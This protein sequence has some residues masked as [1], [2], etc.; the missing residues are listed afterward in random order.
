MSLFKLHID[1]EKETVAKL[2]EED[3]IVVDG[4]LEWYNTAEI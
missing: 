1:I 2:Q 3:E 4:Y